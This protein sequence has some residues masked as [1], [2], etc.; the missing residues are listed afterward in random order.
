MIPRYAL[1]E[2]TAVW[3]DERKFELWLQVEVAVVQA[4]GDE[5]VVPMEDVRLVEANARVHVP[6]VMRYIEETHHDVTAFLRSVADSLGPES[7]WIHYG[8]TSN[9]VWDTATCLQMAAA[10]DLIDTRVKRLREVVERRAVEHKDTICIGRTHGVHAEPTTFGMKLAVWVDELR[11][12]EERIAPASR[13]P[14]GRCRGQSGR[15]PRCHRP[16]RKTPASASDWRWRR[17]PHR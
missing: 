13:S 9:D 8:L 14:S 7:R 1:P 4:W 5:G 12:Q 3:S 11:R 2:M 16:S 15:T 10:L 17:S 6:N